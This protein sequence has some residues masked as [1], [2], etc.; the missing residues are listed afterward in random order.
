M[1][2]IT[3]TLLLP[4]R[5]QHNNSKSARVK[6]DTPWHKRLKSD[7]DATEVKAVNTTKARHGKLCRGILS[8]VHLHALHAL[9]LAFTSTFFHYYF[10]TSWEKPTSPCQTQMRWNQMKW[11]RNRQFHN[12]AFGGAETTFSPHTTFRQQKQSSECKATISFA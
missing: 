1:L 6:G 11:M 5:L 2:D 10:T 3:S 7:K 4:Y 9:L 12:M 8:C